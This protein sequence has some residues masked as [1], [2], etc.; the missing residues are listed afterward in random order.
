MEKSVLYVP[1]FSLCYS[2]SQRIKHFES[3]EAFVSL[4]AAEKNY[5][6]HHRQNY[7]LEC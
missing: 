7:P 5:V 2:E 4:K 1:A 6:F 3:I